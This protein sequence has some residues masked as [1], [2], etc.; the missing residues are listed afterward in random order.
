MWGTISR[1]SQAVPHLENSVRCELSL[2]QKG[3]P[4]ALRIA[5]VRHTWVLATCRCVCPAAMLAS[6]SLALVTSRTVAP[7]T[8]TMPLASFLMSSRGALPCAGL[9]T[10]QPKLRSTG[11]QRQNCEYRFLLTA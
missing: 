4:E 9:H 7:G 10:S 3:P 8:T 5:I 6:S 11:V 2:D 1:C